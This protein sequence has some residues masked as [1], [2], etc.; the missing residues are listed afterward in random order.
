MTRRVTG[1]LFDLDGTLI[2]SADDLAHAMNAV[3]AE[4]GEP[5]VPIARLRPHTARGAA[6]MILEA[7]GYGTDHPDYPTLRARFLE[8]YA[9]SL[10]VH[11]RVWPGM[12]AVIHALE[13][14]GV[15]WGVV[16]NKAARFAEAVVAGLGLTPA[17]LVSG[18][19]TARRKP[20][21]EPLIHAANALKVPTA[22]LAYVGDAISD[23]Q[24]ARAAGMLAVG[25]GYSYFV[26]NH[27][28]RAWGADV[29]VE[30]PDALLGLLK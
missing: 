19:T 15:A 30:A 29:W 13:A 27:D 10:L 6:S 25:A 4:R 14:R 16:T 5:A 23:M 28:R 8:C 21:P 9:Q 2:D 1:L 12:Q 11:T 18:D 7:Y 20:D 26:E 17:V 24:A 22:Q 3:R